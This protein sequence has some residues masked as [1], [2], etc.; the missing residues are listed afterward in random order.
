L[1]PKHQDEVPEKQT[2]RDGHYELG[3]SSGL[4][5]LFSKQDSIGHI[6]PFRNVQRRIW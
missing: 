3:A 2:Y 5:C 6:Q 4:W 1:T